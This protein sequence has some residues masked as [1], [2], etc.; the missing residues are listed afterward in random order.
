M[1]TDRHY[2]RTRD[3]FLLGQVL[4]LGQIADDLATQARTSQYHSRLT[5]ALANGNV[6]KELKDLGLLSQDS[7]GRCKDVLNTASMKCF[8]FKEVA[9]VVLAV[10][11]FSSQA[12]DEDGIPQ[13]VDAKALSIIG[14][15]L[16][17]S[18]NSSFALGVFLE[19][20]ALD[21]MS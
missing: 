9:D 13:S 17:R 19:N 12:R 2:K 16:V 7:D 10:S 1:T 20:I 15:H 5:E 14:E 4:S 8:K 18:I 21:Q 3:K 6:W 11:H